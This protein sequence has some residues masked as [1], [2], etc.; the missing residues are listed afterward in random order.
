MPFDYTNAGVN[1]Y[2]SPEAK[3]MLAKDQDNFSQD[4]KEQAFMAAGVNKT[5]SQP[6]EPTL[7]LSSLETNTTTQEPELDLSSLSEL[8]PGTITVTAP[9]T[10][11]VLKPK[12]MME[13]TLQLTG[14]VV[15]GAAT[16]IAEGFD[17]MT[18]GLPK[19]A[20]NS[21]FDNTPDEQLTED[22]RAYK[23]VGRAVNNASQL[24]VP[25]LTHLLQKTFGSDQDRLDIMDYQKA[26]TQGI[27]DELQTQ[28]IQAEA[29]TND[30]EGDE[31]QGWSIYVKDAQG[32]DIKLDDPS[33]LDSMATEGWT[34]GLGVGGGILGAKTASQ[35]TKNPFLIGAAA[36][37]GAVSGTTTGT[38]LDM[39]KAN[40]KLNNDINGE[41]MKA[42]LAENASL[43]IVSA[44][45]AKPISMLGK[46]AIEGAN[47]IKNYIFKGNV[48]GA[49]KEALIHTGLTREEGL[50]LVEE[51]SKFYNVD[52]DA[53]WLN[54][55][56]Q[57]QEDLM[58]L[59]TLG[60][61]SSKMGGPVADIRASDRA[62]RNATIDLTNRAN[63]VI[64]KV[65]S[66][67]PGV[68]V[69]V[70]QKDLPDYIKNVKA[71]YGDVKNSFAEFT[72]DYRFDLGN[73]IKGVK[74]QIPTQFKD[75]AIE[76]K[77]VRFLSD[78]ENNTIPRDGEA[79]IRFKQELG[80]FIHENKSKMS[81]DVSK[82]LG[83]LAKAVDNEILRVGDQLVPENT[84]WKSG[85]KTANEEYSKMKSLEINSLY[86]ALTRPG[87]SQDD[88][89]RTF[90]NYADTYD[91]TF[92][93]VVS[94]LPKETRSKIDN[95]MMKHFVDKNTLGIGTDMQAIDFIKLDSQLK[96]VKFS[97]P[98]MIA[99]KDVIRQ[100][101]K[102]F[103][104]DKALFQ[105]AGGL[106]RPS[107]G[108]TIATTAEGKV[109]AGIIQTL[110]DMFKSRIP[111]EGGRVRALFSALKTSFENPLDVKAYDEIVKQLPIDQ[112][113]IRN[114]LSFASQMQQMRATYAGAKNYQQ[115][116]GNVTPSIEATSSAPLEAEVIDFGSDAYKNIKS[117][118]NPI[119]VYSGEANDIIEAEIY[120][121]QRLVITKDGHILPMEQL[122]QGER[123]PD[124]MRL[125]AKVETPVKSFFDMRMK[126]KTE[127]DL[128]KARNDVANA[129][130]EAVKA[131]LKQRLV[132]LLNYHKLR[133]EGL[134]PAE[135]HRA[136]YG[137]KN[138][139]KTQMSA[140]V[141]AGLIGGGLNGVTI[142]DDGDIE[143]DVN[144]FMVGFG[145][146]VVGVSGAK[147]LGKTY[148]E[149][150][151][152]AMQQ[153]GGGIPPQ[154]FPIDY[155]TKSIDAL[156]EMIKKKPNLRMNYD[157]LTRF[158]K[159]R[160]VSEGEISQ[161]GRLATE[162][163]GDSRALP[164]SDWED[165]INRKTYEG[166]VKPSSIYSNESYSDITLGKSGTFLNADYQV[167]E[168][169]ANTPT[170]GRMPT[171]HE[172]E[173][174][175]NAGLIKTK[176]IEQL[177]WNRTHFDKIDLGT[178]QEDV[179]VLN[180]LQ[181]DW[182]QAER[183]GKGL[184]QSTDLD[185]FKA[186]L[187][188]SEKKLEEL[189]LKYSS[190]DN[191]PI[192]PD[193]H[194]AVMNEQKELKK[195]I[196]QLEDKIKYA[197]SS[198]KESDVLDTKTA[199]K[200]YE[201]AKQKQTDL[202]DA[203]FNYY[204]TNTDE[205]LDK[206]TEAQNEYRQ[207]IVDK[208]FKSKY[209][210]VDSITRL[211]SGAQQDLQNVVEYVLETDSN[212]KKISNEVD[213]LSE[214]AIAA[215]HNITKRED[216][217]KLL[218]L[219]KDV[220]E[221]NRVLWSAASEVNRAIAFKKTGS[222]IADFPMKQDKFSTLAIIDS[223][224]RAVEGG[225]D[226]VVI[227]IQREKE[228]VGKA[229][230]TKFY[231][232]L[233]NSVIPRLIKQFK[234]QGVELKYSRAPY[235]KHYGSA[236]FT[237][238]LHV[239]KIDMKNSKIPPE[240]IKHQLYKIAG[241]ISAGGAAYEAEAGFTKEDKIVNTKIKVPN[242]AI[243][244]LELFEGKDLFHSKKDKGNTAL[245]LGADLKNEDPEIARQ[246]KAYAGIKEGKPITD[247]QSRK[248]GQAMVMHR[249]GLLTKY[250]TFDE[251]T[252]NKLLNL[253]VFDNRLVTW[254]QNNKNKSPMNYIKN[255]A[256]TSDNENIKDRHTFTY[257]NL[258]D[259]N[260]KATDKMIDI[261][262]NKVIR[263]KSQS[264][265]TILS[266]KKLIESYKAGNKD[267]FYTQA[268]NA[269]YISEKDYKYL[270][271]KRNYTKVKGG[272][273]GLFK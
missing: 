77:L 96:N 162:F 261:M 181:S 34:I 122:L 240:G 70:I 158:L 131:R 66:A 182:M 47:I 65:A 95:A 48:G 58:L 267:E 98:E 97:D 11:K 178:G 71:F 269:K 15:T 89:I 59:R 246:I 171:H 12:T 85:W 113:D 271:P 163:K 272:V 222:R 153:A 36:L 26:L 259:R 44:A 111:T 41:Q 235:S 43:E 201:E 20:F 156:Q 23:E 253:A 7:D 168:F 199:N 170:S 140:E 165:M 205:K 121:N 225:V 86:K 10:P 219:D 123:L 67:D 192:G 197:K 202:L 229:G 183:A 73:V 144:K 262:L 190:L 75:P 37:T 1:N 91:N 74:E 21:V 152:L 24:K 30:A 5:N 6:A 143:V 25:S 234:A 138:G 16:S 204:T 242:K 216:L 139:V 211:D 213:I 101:S 134:K 247:E 255:V 72:K 177:G 224:Q 63:I 82:N 61:T 252:K 132:N 208:I 231:E 112:R 136:V 42:K 53:P 90:A 237:N 189:T 149:G 103:K 93:D 32:N 79:L 210:G 221:A 198:I 76:N 175:L 14:D 254:L 126:L 94:K 127:P 195:E 226:T 270:V 115:G 147:K 173:D 220:E 185:T 212:Y 233:G 137:D 265:D 45:L 38:L 157:E 39:L 264:L 99:H 167:N 4:F 169:T 40:I 239:L 129:K 49:V 108:N 3:D 243:S 17:V 180:E 203:K 174:G 119:M 84:I 193:T 141:T 146:G 128:I 172:F 257:I 250:G 217:L 142:D 241:T 228:L 35:F 31:S 110:W 209:P 196:G 188:D 55:N 191:K 186:K 154:Q 268:Y 87:Q 118:E 13:Q 155:T 273:S 187:A 102:L 107:S 27:I 214:V 81:Y 159:A 83:N 184:F 150:E 51:Y 105:Y 164:L 50:K 161:L 145:A 120:P 151:E 60:S 29:R 223:I 133:D 68:A 9:K 28:G 54:S 200:L 194:Y 245:Y 2:A 179:L 148:V 260:N 218:K 62:I 130:D 52:L 124:N 256:N 56:K 46:G 176:K 109:K 249:Y 166:G 57:L 230:V 258:L 207:A 206:A 114:P 116:M 106:A 248:A 125:P 215:Q 8:E 22:Q 92:F 104:N 88:L 251:D 135:A 236:S 232:S 69:E 64:D 117:Q 78:I 238:D 19:K 80:D 100:M 266:N 244:N 33:M 18:F 263:G 227:P 160:G